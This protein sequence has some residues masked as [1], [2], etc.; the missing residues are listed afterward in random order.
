MGISMSGDLFLV[1]TGVCRAMRKPGS[2]VPPHPPAPG[3]AKM[4]DFFL[5]LSEDTLTRIVKAK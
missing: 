1:G 3:A 5:E 4:L 2:T